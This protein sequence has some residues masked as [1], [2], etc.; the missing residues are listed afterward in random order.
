MAD[1]ILTTSFS[2]NTMPYIELYERGLAWGEVSR[3]GARALSARFH[4]WARVF[5]LQSPT[6]GGLAPGGRAWSR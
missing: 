1:A 4:R 5:V 3:L 6:S 2:D